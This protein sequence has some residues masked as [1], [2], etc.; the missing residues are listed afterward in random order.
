MLQFEKRVPDSLR[1][2]QSLDALC[3]PV[4]ANPNYNP[5][6]VWGTDI[7]YI[8]T[9]E[10]RV[11]LAVLMDLYSRIVVAWSM[12]PTLMR[13]LVLDAL[14]MAVWRRRPEQPARSE[15]LGFHGQRWWNLESSFEQTQSR[16]ERMQ[17]SML[18]GTSIRVWIVLSRSQTSSGVKTH[19]L[20]WFRFTHWLM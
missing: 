17:S 6:R 18:K 3:G 1:K 9:F 15:E 4:C 16:P 12:K 19:T 7:T 14:L 11:Y 5:D 2:A 20:R 8:R 10:G 13:E